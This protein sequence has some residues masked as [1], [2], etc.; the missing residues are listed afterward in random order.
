MDDVASKS[1]SSSSKVES[2]ATS[3]ELPWYI[4]VPIA[5]VGMLVLAGLG[6]LI[7]HFVLSPAWEILRE[8]FLGGDP[9]GIARLSSFIALIAVAVSLVA[10]FYAGVRPI[11]RGSDWYKARLTD[12]EPVY[13]DELSDIRKLISRL[14]SSS[15]DEVISRKLTEAVKNIKNELQDEIK[16]NLDISDPAKLFTAARQRLLNE[17]IR[18]DSI[19]RRNLIFGILFSAF[20]LGFL[21]WP[22]VAQTLFV[23]LQPSSS[24]D[25]DVFRWVAQSYLPRFAVGLLLQF[26][27]FFFLRLYVANEL[28]LKHNKNEITNI[29]LKMLALQVANNEK[30]SAS[31]KTVIKSLAETERNFILRKNE[32]TVSGDFNAEYNDMKSLLEKALEKVPAVRGVVRK[33]S[34]P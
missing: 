14:Q 25:G 21:A 22:L 17:A 32:K 19:S 29:E 1:T 5:I 30:D 31:K 24:P 12:K 2:K 20:A 4:A 7:F 13:R 18:I 34:A 8:Y 26:V 11:L 23:N 3:D 10:L 27:G 16:S 9:S 33:P 28:D 6:Y 15:A